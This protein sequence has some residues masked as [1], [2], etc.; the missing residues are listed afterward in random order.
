MLESQIKLILL[1]LQQQTDIN[2]SKYVP[3]FVKPVISNII[4]MT[5]NAGFDITKV[6]SM[7]NFNVENARALANF[8][9]SCYFG[10]S[11]QLLFVMHD[12]RTMIVNNTN[13]LQPNFPTP[14]NV[15]K[16]S[17]I[18]AYGNIKDLLIEMNVSPKTTP[19]TIFSNY[20]FVKQNIFDIP[21]VTL[22]EEDAE[23]FISFFT[24]RLR[25][26]IRDLFLMKGVREYYRAG[27]GQL[28]SST[29]YEFSFNFINF[30]IIKT[31]LNATLEQ[32]L[33]Q[34]QM[35]QI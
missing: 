18:T 15:T 30:D 29:P 17:M 25:N 26:E 23:E 34:L 32:T 27:D 31:N 33:Y 21:S 12:L 28:M 7:Y 16:S 1:I 9:N 11:M 14:I 5:F 19:I 6:M 24:S 4:D 3:K 2:L 22:V 8:G 10:V 20:K 13:F 35:K